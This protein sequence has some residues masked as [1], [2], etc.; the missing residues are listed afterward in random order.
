M[1]LWETATRVVRGAF[2]RPNVRHELRAQADEPNRSTSA[3]WRG[4]ATPLQGQRWSVRT[5]LL[6]SSKKQVDGSAADSRDGT[7]DLQIVA[8]D[9][10]EANLIFSV[11]VRV[12]A[13]VIV[14]IDL[15]FLLVNRVPAKVRDASLDNCLVFLGS[16]TEAIAG[17]ELRQCSSLEDKN[18]APASIVNHDTF[19]LRS[20]RF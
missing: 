16:T 8:R 11:P 12:S 14:Q 6:S 19:W 2:V 9:L 15:A 4:W 18:K 7:D 17:G 5:P 3:R 1:I 10:H 20:E 13:A